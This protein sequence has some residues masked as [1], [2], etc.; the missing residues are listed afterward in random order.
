MRE[1]TR[2]DDSQV[3]GLSSCWMVPFSEAGKRGEGRRKRIVA[4]GGED[5]EFPF[6]SVELRSLR[7][8]QGEISRTLK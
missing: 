7:D 2:K 6:G 5:D 1:Q 3:V 8:V 4:R